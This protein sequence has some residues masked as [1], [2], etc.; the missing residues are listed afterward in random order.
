MPIIISLSTSTAENQKR[1]LG[2]GGMKGTLGN[3]RERARRIKE[4]FA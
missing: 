1:R 2:N 3:K 4:L